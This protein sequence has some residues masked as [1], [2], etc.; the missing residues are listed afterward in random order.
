MDAEDPGETICYIAN[1]DPTTSYSSGGIL[2]TFK[3]TAKT[4]QLVIKI[5]DSIS[6]NKAREFIV[7]LDILDMV[8]D[9]TLMFQYNSEEGESYHFFLNG[10]DVTNGV[11]I[12]NKKTV[13]KFV[14]LRHGV[15]AIDEMS[16]TDYFNV[17]T[18]SALTGDIDVLRVSKNA[19]ISVETVVDS[20]ISSLVATDLTGTTVSAVQ[21]TADTANISTENVVSADV[22][23]MRVNKLT[24]QDEDFGTLSGS[25]LTVLTASISSLNVSQTNISGLTATVEF[26][27]DLS[28]NTVSANML[29]AVSTNLSTSNVLTSHVGEMNVDNLSG[30]NLSIANEVVTNLTATDE[31]FGTLSGA[32][33]TALSA[34]VSSLV[35]TS[36]IIDNLTATSESVNDLSVTNLTAVTSNLSTVHV[37]TADIDTLTVSKEQV[38]NLSGVNISSSALTAVTTNLSTSHVLSSDVENLTA[39]SEFATNLTA[40][41][42]SAHTLT[43]DQISVGLNNI[44]FVDGT[45]ISSAS[46]ISSNFQTQINDINDDVEELSGKHATLKDRIDNT[47]VD[48][49]S[50]VNESAVPEYLMLRDVDNRSNLYVLQVKSGRLVINLVDFTPVEG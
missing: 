5:P 13:L 22:E 44:T 6:N 20:K 15:F 49:I 34:S 14:E 35:A 17:T 50:S 43:A 45:V 18:M 32:N 16:N 25:S 7:V 41:N 24:A 40:V 39:T 9:T 31:K 28:A 2:D 42:I 8:N 1:Y 19:T 4:S 47:I 21:F 3:P 26:A 12:H 29:T 27:E 10:T 33:L 23:K 36:S 30:S 48:E 38:E 11:K 37:G 46:Q